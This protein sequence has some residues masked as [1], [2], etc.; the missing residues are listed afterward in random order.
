MEGGGLHKPKKP[1][2]FRVKVVEDGNGN[3]IRVDKVDKVFNSQMTEVFQGSNLDE[4][5]DE[6]FAHMKTQIENPALGY[7]VQFGT[8]LNNSILIL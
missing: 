5:I 6:M 8:K 1:G 2:A 4:V 7:G 3:I